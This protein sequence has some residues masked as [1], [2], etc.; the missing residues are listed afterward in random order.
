MSETNLTRGNTTLER[1]EMVRKTMMD[2]FGELS[3]SSWAAA[4]ILTEDKHLYGEVLH[5]YHSNKYAKS[6]DLSYVEANEIEL[7]EESQ[8]LAGLA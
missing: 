8:K 5:Y 7:W 4:D 1:I 3:V 6:S 2:I